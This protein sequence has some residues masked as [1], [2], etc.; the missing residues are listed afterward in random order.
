VHVGSE[1]R[2][3]ARPMASATCTGRAGVAGGI[4]S[5][6]CLAPEFQMEIFFTSAVL[7]AIAEIGDKTMLLAILL[8]TRFKTPLPIIAGIFTAT[9]ANHA[10]AAWAGS[11]LAGFF[12]SD[13]FRYAVAFGFIA[14][15]GWT[16]IPDKVD[17]DM[18][19]ASQRGAFL[20]TTI[21]FFVVEMGDKTQVA[22][23]ALGAQYHSVVAVAAGT[24]LGMMMANVPAVYLGE[25]LVEKV[26]LKV[27]HR[28]A[29][30]MF[31][32]L[33]FWQLWELWN[34]G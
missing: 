32:M 10:L 27:V 17:D 24:T 1:F 2:L 21:A 25:K 5:N 28:V 18:K 12:A 15:A 4:A 29:A 3:K 23:I 11:S 34:G 33:G 8:A 19:V 26:S 31:L 30:A 16:L 22:T 9:I 13:A 6:F 20:A 14:M 7:V